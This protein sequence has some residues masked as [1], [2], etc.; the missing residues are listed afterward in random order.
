MSARILCVTSG[1]TGM[2]YSSIELARRLAAAGHQLTYAGPADTRLL[3][4]RQGLDFLPLEPSRYDEFL[5]SDAGTGSLNRIVNL[6]ERL[7]RAVASLAVGGFTDAVR[8]NRPD[9]LLIDGEMHEHIIAASQTGVPMALLNTF[10]SIWRRP[11]LPP[12][13]CPVRPGVG[14]KGTRPGIAMLWLALRLRKWGIASSLRARRF[15]CDRLSLLRHLA[16]IYDFDLRR[17]TDASQWL[18]PFTYRRLPVLSLHA[19]E[20]DFPHRPPQWVRYVGP[21][22]LEH[23]V[24]RS[25]V[26]VEK[27]ELDAV[28]DQRRDAGQEQKLI[29][30]GFG[31]VFSADRVLLRR[32]FGIVRQ[33]PNWNLVIS[34]SGRVR[35]ADLDPLPERVY[36]F[37]WVPQMDVLRHADV[38]VTHGGINTIDECVVCGVPMLVYCGGE[39][40]MAGNTARIVYHGIGIAGDRR[41]DGT[42][43][44]RRHVDRLLSEP[45]FANNIGRL[46]HRYLAYAEDRVAERAVEELL[47]QPGADLSPPGGGAVS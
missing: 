21:M 47:D 33:R 13:H 36:A 9:L 18:I 25:T 28:F 30:A 20:F 7:R 37:S 42:E 17:E 5:E 11:G 2:L 46:R 27:V 39:T 23:R 44:I 34:L 6:R 16:R 43:D 10:A 15:G 19:F 12:A 22:V 3:V 29:F 32:L 40:D 45:G 26:P 24:D 14:W 8:A 31:S 4:E 38:V 1:L 41:R 35:P